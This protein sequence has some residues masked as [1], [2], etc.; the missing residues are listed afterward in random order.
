MSF[1]SKDLEKLK[2][3]GKTLPTSSSNTK[4]S[5]NKAK[6]TNPKLHPIETEEDPKELFKELIKASSNG[7]VPLHLLKRLRELEDKQTINSDNFENTA[8]HKIDNASTNNKEI[9]SL[10][11]DLYTSFKMLL[12][13][14]D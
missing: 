4:D 5:P 12:L 3:Y 8:I 10:E 7:E 1:N 6:K 2:A 14:E 9:T 11:S 13:E